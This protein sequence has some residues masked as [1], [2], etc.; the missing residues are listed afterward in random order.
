MLELN[1]LMVQLRLLSMSMLILATIT[2]NSKIADIE[3][4]KNLKKM[5]K[6]L[7]YRGRKMNISIVFITQCYFRALKDAR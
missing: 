4:N 3:Y 6:E 7:F 5:T 2:K 1:I